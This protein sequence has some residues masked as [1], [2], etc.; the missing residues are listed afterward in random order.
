[1]I[2]SIANR[3]SIFADLNDKQVSQLKSMMELCSLPADMVIFEQDTVANYFYI[4]VEGEISIRYK[5]YDAP[6]LVIA[7][8]LPG[9]VFGWSAALGRKTYSS[10]AVATQN[11][12]AL[13]F[14]GNALQQL[15]DRC[16][17]TAEVFLDRLA[18]GISE[19]L[20]YAHQDILDLLRNGFDTESECWRRI[21]TNERK[22]R[23]HS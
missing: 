12:K 17:K 14:R 18:R 21:N 11:S 9:D 16:P 8:I 7:R 19:R 22:A 15:C 6:P 13:R 4:L 10:A 23:I 3:L 5:P 1:M 20:K 2:G